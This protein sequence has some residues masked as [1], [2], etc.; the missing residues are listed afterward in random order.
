MN[1]LLI[2][3]R[4]TG[5]TTVA[6]RLALNLGWEWIDADVE[7]E[8]RAGRSIAEIF[9]AAGEAGFRDLESAVLAD[10]LARDRQVVALGGGVVLRPAN[11]AAIRAAGRTVWLQA[12]PQTL[13]QRIAADAT[14]AARRPNLTAAGGISEI[15]AMLAQRQPFY[16]ECAGLAVD[17]ENKTPAEVA[18]EI[19]ARWGAQLRGEPA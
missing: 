3:Y 9:S 5:K 6:Q 14:T 13:S 16:R 10:L 15:T 8:L 18:E 17:T 12:S 19:L 4:G 7:V 11:R 1:L 2:G